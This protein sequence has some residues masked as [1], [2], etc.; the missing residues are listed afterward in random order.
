MEVGKLH[1][2]NQKPALT[3]NLITGLKLLHHCQIKNA[4]STDIGVK[5]VSHCA[6]CLKTKRLI[7]LLSG[8]WVFEPVRDNYCQSIYIAN[9]KEDQMSTVGLRSL[10]TACLW[11]AASNE[12]YPDFNS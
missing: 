3:I 1:L 10:E 11:E 4:H 5:T 12:K 2:G 6:Y 9:G 8:S 7:K